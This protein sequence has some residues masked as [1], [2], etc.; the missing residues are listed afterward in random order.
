MD[1]RGEREKNGLE[2]YGNRKFIL[3]SQLKKYSSQTITNVIIYLLFY[4]L[5]AYFSI[6]MSVKGIS[7]IKKIKL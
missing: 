5:L 6:R 7:K 3:P 1:Y 4:V 2:Q